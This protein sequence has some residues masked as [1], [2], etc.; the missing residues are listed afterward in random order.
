[1]EMRYL[2]NQL[3]DAHTEQLCVVTINNSL[4]GFPSSFVEIKKI[5]GGVFLKEYFKIST[6]DESQLN[7]MLSRGWEVIETSKRNTDGDEYV[8]YHI[9]FPIRKALE[10]ALDVLKEYD[11]HDFRLKLIESVAEE[12]NA[13]L[14]DYEPTSR[15]FNYASDSVTD[16][17]E[18][19]DF[20]LSGN[21]F[22][23]YRK[24]KK[25]ELDYNIEF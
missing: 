21:D 12:I 7:V 25:E 18:K 9:G 22:P 15:L 11:N 20:L 5:K 16:I 17:Y 3:S 2:Q 6:I 23:K 24:M 19:T 13:N 1:M 8:S 14:D 4:E 10:I